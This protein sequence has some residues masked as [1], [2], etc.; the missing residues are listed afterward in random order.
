MAVATSRPV[1]GPAAERRLTAVHGAYRRRRAQGRRR[2][3]RPPVWRLD[4]DHR[5][6]YPRRRR[7]RGGAT[8]VGH[9]HARGPARRRPRRCAGV[10]RRPAGECPRARLHPLLDERGAAPSGP[11]L[12]PEAHYAHRPRHRAVDH[13]ADRPGDA[14]PRARANLARRQRHWPSDPAHELTGGGRSLFGQSRNRRVHPDRR[15]QQR[16][17]GGRSDPERTAGRAWTREPARR[18]LAPV[19]A[20]S[21]RALAR[22]RSAGRDGALD[23]AARL[24]QIDDRG[25]ART[26]AGRHRTV[27]LPARRRQHQTWALRGPR[28]LPG[29]PLGAHSSRRPGTRG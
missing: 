22:D 13:R 7:A 29:R 2:S 12:R 15:G 24:R 17:G 5:A 11:T 1:G 4:H 18:H 14:R 27:G 19:G 26:P 8:V 6:R 16:D 21:R 10:A 3:G 25:R 23:R 28:I 9:V 20:R